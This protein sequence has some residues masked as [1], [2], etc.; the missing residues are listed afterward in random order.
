MSVGA[1]FALTR[2]RP[3]WRAVAMSVVSIIQRRHRVYLDS[4]AILTANKNERNIPR[5]YWNFFLDI[6]GARIVLVAR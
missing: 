4:G 6:S 2:L 1:I 3:V 5:K